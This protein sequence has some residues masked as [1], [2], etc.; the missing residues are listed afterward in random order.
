MRHV[1]A[2]AGTAAARR[3][4]GVSPRYCSPRHTCHTYHTIFNLVEISGYGGVRAVTM[5][6]R[7]RSCSIRVVGGARYDAPSAGA[8][9]PRVT[10]MEVLVWQV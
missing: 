10:P 5:C 2:T 6:A 4:D 3:C 1:I 7:R 8:G 9:L